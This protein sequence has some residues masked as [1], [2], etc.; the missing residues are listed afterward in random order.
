MKLINCFVL[1]ISHRRCY[2]RNGSTGARVM[3]NKWS[4]IDAM[5]ARNCLQVSDIDPH[6]HLRRHIILKLHAL[7]NL[8]G[9]ECIF[10]Q[11]IC[12]LY[13]FSELSFNILTNQTM[14]QRQGMTKSVFL[15]WKSLSDDLRMNGHAIKEI[16]DTIKLG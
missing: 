13:S 6:E 11:N 15:A 16:V 3:I 7:V 5:S 4:Q 12:F 1:L 10:K 14:S 2:P 9:T 8:P